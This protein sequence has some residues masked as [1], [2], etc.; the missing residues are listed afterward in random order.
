MFFNLKMPLLQSAASQDRQR[1][2]LSQR[3]LQQ[4]VL[5]LRMPRALE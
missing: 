5:D 1:L 3:S 2:Q 4:R